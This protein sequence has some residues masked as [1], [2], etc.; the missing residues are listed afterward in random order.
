MYGRD[1]GNDVAKY[2]KIHKGITITV[3][4]VSTRFGILWQASNDY[5][6]PVNEVRAYK[7]VQDAFSGERAE[8]DAMFAATRPKAN[9]LREIVK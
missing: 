2:T 5:G 7:T 8:L 4:S 9:F 3:E 6:E 1:G